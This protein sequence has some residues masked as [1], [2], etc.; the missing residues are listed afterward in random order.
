MVFHPCHTHNNQ[1]GWVPGAIVPYHRVGD[2][3]MPPLFGLTEIGWKQLWLSSSG[4]TSPLITDSLGVCF[5]ELWRQWAAGYFAA[6]NYGSVKDDGGV[7]AARSTFCDSDVEIGLQL[8]IL[9]SMQEYKTFFFFLP[10]VVE[11]LRN[12]I[13]IYPVF[14]DWTVQ[15]L[16]YFIC[17]MATQHPVFLGLHLRRSQ[18]TKCCASASAND[19]EC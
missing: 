3:L 19:W 11:I 18:V 2:G 13:S 6:C 17:W 9:Q 10:K 12:F 4:I 14:R 5:S 7:Q 8:C 1:I 15:Y 16:G